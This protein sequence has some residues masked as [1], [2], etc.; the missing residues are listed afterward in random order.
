MRL[1]TP[2][3]WYALFWIAVWLA[4][5]GVARLVLVRPLLQRMDRLIELYET[6]RHG[7]SD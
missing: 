7:S 2:E 6:T 1:V 3:R 4:T 5:F